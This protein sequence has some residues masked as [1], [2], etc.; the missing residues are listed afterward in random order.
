MDFIY[1]KRIEFLDC[2]P[3]GFVK[4][5][6]YQELML[7]GSMALFRNEGVD[8]HKEIEKELGLYFAG[9]KV[10]IEF[11]GIARPY[12][13]VDIHVGV[14]YIKNFSIKFVYTF[15]RGDTLLAKGYME[16]ACISSDG[17]FGEIPE[18]VHKK[19]EKYIL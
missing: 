5:S 18:W 19:F 8:Y 1:Q 7:A 13:M 9:K 4:N 3:T 15:Y 6:Y 10:Q 17:E 12:D 11:S 2:D 14:E 16:H